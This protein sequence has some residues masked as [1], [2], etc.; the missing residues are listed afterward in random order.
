MDQHTVGNDRLTESLVQLLT[1]AH[2]AATPDAKATV[3]LEIV[4]SGATT[5]EADIRSP[6][7]QVYRRRNDG[8]D[9]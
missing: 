7:E 2:P 1:V 4:Y 8:V 3:V 5:H 6:R 9:K